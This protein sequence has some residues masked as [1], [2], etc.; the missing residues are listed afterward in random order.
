MPPVTAQ[1]IQT[2]Q[3]PRMILQG[4]QGTQLQQAQRANIHRRVKQQ[5]LKQQALARQQGKVPPTRVTIQLPEHIGRETE[6]AASQSDEPAKGEESGGTPQS[7]QS[8]GEEEGLLT[9]QEERGQQ[10]A[11][12]TTERTQPRPDRRKRSEGRTL[13]GET[14][15]YTYQG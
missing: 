9:D 15:K 5:V 11:R 13:K 6:T 7:H 8:A 1:L 3:G 12:G 2:N 4:L 10:P 14:R